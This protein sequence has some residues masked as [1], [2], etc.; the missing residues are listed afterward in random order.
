MKI[1]F[2]AEE[3]ILLI[4]LVSQFKRSEMVPH[5]RQNEIQQILDRLSLLSEAISNEKELELQRKELERA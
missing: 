5:F 1:D 4:E 2:N 3:T